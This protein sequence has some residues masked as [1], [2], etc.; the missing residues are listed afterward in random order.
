MFTPKISFKYQ[1]RTLASGRASYFT[2]MSVFTLQS[3]SVNSLPQAAG[4]A[5]RRG[6]VLGLGP[7]RAELQCRRLRRTETH[8]TVPTSDGP[9]SP[10][11]KS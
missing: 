3:L 10:A 6:A 5:A 4:S 7:Q 2:Q 9:D 8:W 1:I 11:P